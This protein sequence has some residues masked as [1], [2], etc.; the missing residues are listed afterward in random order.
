M[1]GYLDIARDSIDASGMRII[2]AVSSWAIVVDITWKSSFSPVRLQGDT[3]SA[4]VYGPVGTTGDMIAV[5]INVENSNYRQ[6]AIRIASTVTDPGSSTYPQ[7]DQ[8]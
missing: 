5:Q 4:D 6:G 2:S 3:P 1:Q 7:T 8:V